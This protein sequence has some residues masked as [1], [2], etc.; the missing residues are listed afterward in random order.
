MYFVSSFIQHKPINFT[1]LHVATT[2]FAHFFPF[3]LYVTALYEHANVY[4]TMLLFL[5]LIL[6]PEF[7]N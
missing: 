7:Y 6:F 3:F 1:Q 2:H 5:S 4:S